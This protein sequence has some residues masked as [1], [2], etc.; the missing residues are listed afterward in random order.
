MP[1]RIIKES[2]CTSCDI[3]Q[4]SPMEEVFFYRLIV[5]CDD[6]GRMDGRAPILRAKCFPLRLGKVSDAMVDGFLTKLVSVGMVQKYVV[7]GKPYIQISA[8]EKHQ[9]QRA[10]RSKY[11]SPDGNGYQVI[12]D[13]PVIQSESER[14]TE[15]TEEKENTKEKE[16]K[17]KIKPGVFLSASECERLIG[18]FGEVGANERITTFSESKLAHGYKYKSDYHAI[19]T[20]ARKDEHKGN[21]HKP[22]GQDPDKFVKGKFAHMV[23]R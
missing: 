21:G 16:A 9:Q 7:T 11:P 22:G 18:Q 17:Y 2:I 8:W 4:L 20:W 3:E 12:S 10:K 1:N 15:S 13:A 6:Y 14:E 19:L 23:H 5:N